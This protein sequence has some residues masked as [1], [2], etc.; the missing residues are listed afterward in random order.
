M[1]LKKGYNSNS[2]S[3]VFKAL[4][5]HLSGNSVKIHE[6]PRSWKP[7]SG[8]RTEPRTSE[9]RSRETY[10]INGNSHFFRLKQESNVC[11]LWRCW[12]D[13]KPERDTWF[14]FVGAL[15]RCLGVRRSSAGFNYVHPGEVILTT[16]KSEFSLAWLTLCA[17]VPV[18]WSISV[19]KQPAEMLFQNAPRF[20]LWYSS[21]NLLPDQNMGNSLPFMNSS[22]EAQ[23][24]FN[25][26]A[27][28]N[29]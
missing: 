3:N 15:I 12:D 8:T 21:V 23:M 13:C 6:G 26:Y 27:F 5:R 17:Y 20:T 19:A 4:W 24:Q 1:T 10:S 16:C 14:L 7:A 9:I 11:M 28:S 22:N 25:I 18:T 2:N 29:Q